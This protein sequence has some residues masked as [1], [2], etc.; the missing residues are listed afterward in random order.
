MCTETPTPCRDQLALLAVIEVLLDAGGAVLAVPV[1]WGCQNFSHSSLILP[2]EIAC[3]YD[4][5]MAK[6]DTSTGAA[7]DKD[8]S[9]NDSGGRFSLHRLS[10]AFA[11]L[12]SNEP[13]PASTDEVADR[14][15]KVDSL[16]DYDEVGE[17]VSPRMIVEGM[18]FVGSEDSRP[19]T[20]RQLATYI[21]DV[22][23]TEV[24]AL[25]EELN[26]E[27]EQA[28]TAYR[29]I[30]NGPGY[31]MQIAEEFKTVR[32]RFQRPV[33]EVK[34]TPQSIEVLSI[35]AYRQPI[36]AER[37][38]KLRGSRSNTLL[39]HLVRRQLLRLE[40][41]EESVKKPSYLTT[42]RFN[43]LFGIASPKDLPSSE[44]LDDQ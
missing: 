31:Q 39:N 1:H 15:D 20:S 9:E 29:I 42:D 25:V 5:P 3:N 38:N 34:L 13:Q 11:R 36:T 40:R 22:S 37:V 7:H 23:P 10:A 24:D 12:T 32:R 44:D 16:S 4:P 30:S 14:L 8:E 18:L 26:D 6:K 33:R 41:A 2:A 28:G 19:I 43:Q 17:V 27:Y 35:V 21:R